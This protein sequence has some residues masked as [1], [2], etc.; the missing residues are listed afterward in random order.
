MPTVPIPSQ[1]GCPVAVA[2]PTPPRARTSPSRA[3]AS[4]SST[5]GSSGVLACRMKPS[6]LSAPFG[7]RDSAIAVRSENASRP[8]ASTSTTSATAGES[9]W[10]GWRSFDTPS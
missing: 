1:A 8:M 2:N 10:C 5:T 3:A 6:Q 7:P 4:S 9:R